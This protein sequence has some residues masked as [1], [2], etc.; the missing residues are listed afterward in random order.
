MPLDLQPFLLI[1]MGCLWIDLE[2]ATSPF[3]FD[4][5]VTQLF[6]RVKRE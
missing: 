5:A 3:E 2:E 1:S 4:P 6:F